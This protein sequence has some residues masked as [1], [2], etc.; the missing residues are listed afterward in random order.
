MSTAPANRGLVALFKRGWHE[1]PEIVGSS[2]MAA[3][4]IGLSFYSLYLY[5]KKDGDNRR[6]K[7]RYTVYRHDDPRVARIRKD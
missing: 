4:G 1:I 2:F 5:T 3:F 6:Y 7:D